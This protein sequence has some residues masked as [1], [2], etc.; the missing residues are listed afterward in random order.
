MNA[1]LFFNIDIIVT[2]RLIVIGYVAIGD[3]LSETAVRGIDI[4]SS[5]VPAFSIPE[6]SFG[7]PNKRKIQRIQ[8]NNVNEL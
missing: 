1:S 7:P 8:S 6:N 2:I 4:M 5:S 3:W